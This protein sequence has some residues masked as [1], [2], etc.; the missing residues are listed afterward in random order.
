MAYLLSLLLSEAVCCAWVTHKTGSNAASAS[1]ETTA[2][3]NEIAENS[4]NP[5]K[6]S[7]DDVT[8]AGSAS[9]QMTSFNNAASAIVKVAEMITEISEQTNL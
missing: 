8:M 5:P 4:E 3:I 2:S 6:I 1:E 7:D 9:G